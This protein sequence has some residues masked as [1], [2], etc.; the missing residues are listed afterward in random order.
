MV[1]GTPGKIQNGLWLL[2]GKGSCTY[3]L[4]GKECSILINGGMSF[5]VPEILEQI[6]KFGIDES[7]ISQMLILHSHFDHV[8]IVPF[9]KRRHPDMVI[10]ASA[11]SLNIFKKPKAIHAINKAGHYAIKQLGLTELCSQYDLDWQLGISGE[12]VSEGDIIDIGDMHVNIFETPG[13]SSCSVAAYVPKLK[14]LFPS[15]AGGV[16]QGDRIVTYGTS[17]YTKFEESLHKLKDLE[18]HYLCADHYG[19]VKGTDALGYI[20]KAIETARQRRKLIDET[21][22]RT[23][24]L[25][26]A[27]RQLAA[28]LSCE[29]KGYIPPDVFIEA[30]RQ[31]IIHIAGLR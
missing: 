19:Y 12:A 1:T 20:G 11:P 29:N 18:V 3:L 16:P 9:F 5:T 26:E 17:N 4:E 23:G 6:S 25:E 13:H 28:Q 7:K 14:A 24:N 30:F 8:G 22:R 2:G 31:M 10:Y 15:D 27:A 21:Y